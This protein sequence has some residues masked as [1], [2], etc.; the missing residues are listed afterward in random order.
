MPDLPATPGSS[1][2]NATFNALLAAAASLEAD[3]AANSAQVSANNDYV[4]A[5]TTQNGDLTATAASALQVAAGLRSLVPAPAP[6]A[7]LF[8][9]GLLGKVVAG[10]KFAG[11]FANL[12]AALEALTAHVRD[13]ASKV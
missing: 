8:G 13:L 7:A 5:L 12:L 1:G 11:S 4:A 9:G 2:I 6:Q 3:A 10:G